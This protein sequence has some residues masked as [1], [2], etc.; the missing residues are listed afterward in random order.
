M[1]LALSLLFVLLIASGAISTTTTQGPR[2][3]NIKDNRIADGCGCYFQFPGSKRS[4]EKYMFFSSVEERP[5]KEAWMNIDGQDVKL[6]LTSKTDPKGREK[7]GS[8]SSRTYTAEGIRLDVT[9]V[10]TRVC[11]VNE[12]SCEST[13]YNATFKLMV[14]GV[15]RTIKAVG[16]CGC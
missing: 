5:E 2:V 11:G 7:V 16:G 8:R 13:D 3:G 1:R 6:K 10:A 4:S 15:Q 14:R 12:E 9:Y